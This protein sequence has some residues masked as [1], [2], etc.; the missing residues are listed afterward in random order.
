MVFAGDI[1]DLLVGDSQFFYQKH[2]AFFKI[3]S[4]LHQ[5]KVKLKYIEGNHDFQIQNLFQKG[6]VAFHDESVVIEVTE[7]NKRIFIA[8]G[9]LV[10]LEDLGYLRLRRFLRSSFMKFM[11]ALAPGKLI[12]KIGEISSRPLYQKEAELPQAWTEKKVLALRKVFRNFA[13][14]K[15]RQGFDYIILGHCHDLDEVTP[16]YWNMGYPPTHRQFLYYDATNSLEKD[17]LNRRNF[18]G[19]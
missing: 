9:D 11:I 6:E 12:Q 19:F 17:L 8:H 4:R 13:E 2:E 14:S 1:F 7:K 10:D 3:L 15:K 5:N 18:P 16:Y